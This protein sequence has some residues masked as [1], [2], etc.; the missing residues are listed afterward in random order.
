MVTRSCG[1]DGTLNSRT[2]DHNGAHT[3]L[4]TIG[5]LD[6]DIERSIAQLTVYSVLFERRRDAWVDFD[7]IV[8]GFD[9]ED[10]LRDSNPV[11]GCRTCEP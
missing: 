11:P 4:T 2:I 6:G 5:I 3:A 8:G 1:D 10:V 7:A 9:T